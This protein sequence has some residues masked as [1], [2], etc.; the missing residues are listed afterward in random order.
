MIHY[1]LRC[2]SG[3][4]FDGWFKSSDGFEEQSAAHMV[5][6]P[7]CGSVHVERA[8]MAPMLPRKNREIMRPSETPSEL[9]LPQT[10]GGAIPDAVRSAL[11]KLREEVEKNCE[12]VGADFVEEARRIH[13]GE[14]KPRGIYGESSEEDVE[15]LAEDGIGVARIPW[16]P[17][18]DS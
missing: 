11:Q 6:C 16:M 5:S 14:A 12:Y 1:Q 9:G 3:H 18:N 7:S 15:A 8:L 17:R 2:E 10:A 4:E 13:Y